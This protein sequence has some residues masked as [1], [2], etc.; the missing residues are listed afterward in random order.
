MN[1]Y[2]K[3][4]PIFDND[5]DLIFFDSTAS[6]Q[7]PKMVIDGIS[8]YL[9]NSYSNIHRWM[10]DIAI[11]SEKMYV[12]SKK[13]IAETLNADSWREVIYSFNSTYAINLFTQSLRKSNY[14]KAWDKV[15]VSIVEHHANIVPWLILK[16]EIGIEVEFVWVTDNYDLDIDD[17]R[18]KYTPDVKII[19]FTQVSNV[20][21]QVFDLETIWK[22]KRD[23]TLF[24]VDWSQSVPHM[25]VD[26]KKIN[27][28]VLF[29]TGH[30]VFADSG[31]GVL[32]AKGQLLK[33]LK[34]AFSWGGAIAEVES[35]YYTEAW[36]PDKFEPG[37]P[38]MTWAVSLLKAFEYIKS[39]GWYNT[40]E[41]HEQT[42][43]EYFLEKAN[44]LPSLEMIGSKEK[45]NRIT[46]FTFSIKWHHSDDVAEILAEQ[47]IAVRSWK[48]CAHPL[49]KSKTNSW[50]IRASLYIYN[51]KSEI[52]KMFKILKTL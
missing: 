37:T 41:N 4:F 38:N 19:S 3:D 26:V 51:D 14:L 17:F 11:E 12:N 23:D 18:Q 35:D 42:L 24:I 10:Y 32:W 34:S 5:K 48:H 52:D 2:K 44:S 49:Y 47:N 46:V 29:F 39:I 16:D 33:S 25:K 22:L 50:A 43:C 27:C 21:W 7:K 28:D 1:N 13:I 40:L 36:L 9:S 15:L 45:T 20:T 31:I 30:K 6:S 8:N